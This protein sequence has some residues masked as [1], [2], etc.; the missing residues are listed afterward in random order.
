MDLSQ[1]QPAPLVAH[2]SPERSRS[3]P[4]GGQAKRCD[5]PRRRAAAV[6]Q[7]RIQAVESKP[8]ELD[9]GVDNGRDDP[10]NSCGASK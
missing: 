2:Q 4:V 6:A 7:R 1:F 5:V 10:I 9:D 8:E 3:P